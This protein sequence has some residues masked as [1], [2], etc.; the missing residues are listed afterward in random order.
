MKNRPIRPL[1]Q[2]RMRV[3]GARS[4]KDVWNVVRATWRLRRMVE[5]YGAEATFDAIVQ[6]ARRN[7]ELNVKVTRGEETL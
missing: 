6:V 2:M 3:Y 7:P 1:V 4:L 5:R